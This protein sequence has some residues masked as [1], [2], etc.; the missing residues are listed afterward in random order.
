MNRESTARHLPFTWDDYRTWSDDERWEVLDGEA[1]AMSPAP[2][3][4]H[5]RVHAAIFNGAFNHFRGRRCEVISSPIDVRLSETDIVQ[6]D[7]VVVCDPKQLTETHV[8]GGPTLVVEILS[9]STAQR[10]RGAKMDAYARAGVREVWLVTPWPP[11]AE[12]FVLDGPTYRRHAAFIQTQTL[13][14]ATFPELEID[15]APVFDFPL[16][17]GEE[18]SIA[19]EPP[20]RRYGGE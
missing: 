19:R 12:V 10:D 17:P 4:R 16:E 8:E 11:C 2:T 13:R 5:Q 9:P 6:P 18:P 1:Y 3:V 15:L 14:G 20:P 7:I